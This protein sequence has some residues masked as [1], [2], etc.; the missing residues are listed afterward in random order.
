MTDTRRTTGRTAARTS[1]APRRLPHL[2]IECVT[3]SLD[4]GRFAVK[5]ILGDSLE[6]SADIFK[7]AKAEVQRDEN[8]ALRHR[9]AHL[10]HRLHVLQHRTHR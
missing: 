1:R 3:P 6:V 2:A 8:V 5:R 9:V 10:R 7:D 4:D